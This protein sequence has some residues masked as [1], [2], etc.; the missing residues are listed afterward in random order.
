M[1]NTDWLCTRSSENIYKMITHP[2]VVASSDAASPAVHVSCRFVRRKGT[3]SPSSQPHCVHPPI[4]SLD[5]SRPLHWRPHS[6]GKSLGAS[7]AMSHTER[8]KAPSK[9]CQGQK[10]C[11]SPHALEA[12]EGQCDLVPSSHAS[13]A[14][15]EGT[16]S[17]V[18]DG[19]SIAGLS[20]AVAPCGNLVMRFSTLSLLTYDRAWSS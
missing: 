17:V 6:V 15:C 4:S 9:H 5:A 16:R 7:E 1:E 12:L 11:A 14:A 2:L 18:R 13:G 10:S 19:Q 3:L 20:G 8:A